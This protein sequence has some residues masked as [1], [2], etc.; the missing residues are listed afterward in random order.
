M[1]TIYSN[2]SEITKTQEEIM[3]I[4]QSWVKREKTPTP[5]KEI[6]SKMIEK[7]FKPVTIADNLSDLVRRGFLR[8][9][10]RSSR[11]YMSYVQLRSV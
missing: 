6:M 11:M 3:L 5:H 8:R 7:E 9:T 10:V 2:Y 1:P 4:V